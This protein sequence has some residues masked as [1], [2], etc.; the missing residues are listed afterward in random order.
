MTIGRREVMFKLLLGTGG[1]VFV[2][3]GSS[4]CVPD[5]DD[6]DATSGE[7]CGGGI[8]ASA[9]DHVVTITLAEVEAAVDAGDGITKESTAAVHS[10]AWSG[11]DEPASS[12]TH[13]VT[14]DHS[15]LNALLTDCEGPY[16]GT[17]T[18]AYNAHTWSFGWVD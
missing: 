7:D 5:D 16:P 14:I 15:T 3:Q 10:H 2:L 6:D 8:E 18:E 17:S 4:G 11:S 13:T 1:T 9:S 12:H